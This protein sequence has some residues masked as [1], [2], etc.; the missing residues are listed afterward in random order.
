MSHNKIK[1]QAPVC[2][3]CGE[4]PE[5]IQEYIDAAYDDDYDSIREWVVENEGTY[6]PAN[7]HFYCTS[8]WDKAGMPIGVAP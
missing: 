1:I 7:G 5:D 6:N 2:V 4:Y 3:G 8:C